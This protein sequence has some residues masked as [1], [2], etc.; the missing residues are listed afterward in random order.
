MHSIQ[1][2]VLSIDASKLVHLSKIRYVLDWLEQH[3]LV[4]VCGVNWHI[5]PD[6]T[7]ENAILLNYGSEKST[8]VDFFFP[9]QN[10]LFGSLPMTFFPKTAPFIF[11]KNAPKIP[12]KSTLNKECD[13]LETLF[14]L[15]SRQEEYQPQKSD[16]DEHGLLRSDAQW[17]VQMGLHHTPV[18]DWLVIAIYQYLGLKPQEKPTKMTISH[19][20]DHVKVFNPKYNLLR[21]MGGVLVRYHKI[22]TVFKLLK[23]YFFPQNG[24]DPYDNLDWMLSK[25]ADIERIM[26]VP[27]ISEAHDLDPDHAVFNEK[28][29]E[30]MQFSLKMGYKIGLHPGYLTWKD[31]ALM[32]Q[33][34]QD[35]E[36]WIGQEINFTRQHYLR[37]SFPETADQIQA[38]GFTEDST[39]GYRDKIGFRCGTG[40][41]YRL[42]DFAN[43]K[44][45]IWY[46]KPLIL[47]DVSIL[48]ESKYDAKQMFAL[49]EDFKNINQKNTHIAI[50]FHNSVF[51]EPDISG[52]PLSELY[53]K[54]IN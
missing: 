9:A 27:A 8:D 48:R 22:S 29:K 21:N 40:F 13:W 51:F 14:F 35:L 52:F 47:M 30:M 25:R 15:L 53:Q 26:Y 1:H 5:N 4:P 12:S 24:K 44:N 42:Y 3:P 54:M 11:E 6:K 45:Y 50:N 18:C 31:E 16:L 34:K 33:Q 49:W 17:L 37:F 32:Q 28:A 46:E 10:A 43:E 23:A 19:D 36:Q 2:I 38:L 7:P 20:L 39:L 41:P